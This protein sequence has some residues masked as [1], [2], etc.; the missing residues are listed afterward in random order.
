MG[1]TTDFEGQFNLNKKLDEATHKLLKGIAETRRMAR[2]LPD[3]YGIEGEFFIDGKGFAGQDRDDTIINYNTPPKTQPSLWLQWV[4]ND[5]GTAIVW[6]E[7]EKFY[8]YIEWIKYLIEKILS[9]RGYI[10]NGQVRWRGE[11]FD[12]IGVITINDNIVSI[13]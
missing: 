13:K 2:N 9:P 12:D 4:P 6:D 5:E 3:E 7:G 8:N 11:D 1:Y 10:L